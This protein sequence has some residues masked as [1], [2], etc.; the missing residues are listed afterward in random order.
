MVGCTL[1]AL[2][3]VERLD[4]SRASYRRAAQSAAF[5]FEIPL[6]RFM[7][8][9]LAGEKITS[10]LVQT[11]RVNP[12]RLLVGSNPTRLILPS[13]SDEAEVVE[14]REAL[15]LAMDKMLDYREREIVERRMGL[16]G[17]KPQ[18]FSEIGQVLNITGIRA[19]QLEKRAMRKLRHD[20]ECNPLRPFIRDEQEIR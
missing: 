1:A 13:P 7:P 9:A 11:A 4:F 8:E 19:Q 2:S 6:A 18:E 5:T 17:Q 15:T 10:K 20:T 14:V 12:E 3:H 16:K